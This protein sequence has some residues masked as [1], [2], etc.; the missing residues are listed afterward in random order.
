MDSRLATPVPGEGHPQSMYVTFGFAMGLL[1]DSHWDAITVARPL[2]RYFMIA[3]QPAN[4]LTSA[5]L[6]IDERI[7]HYLAG[8]NLLDP[9]LQ[10]LVR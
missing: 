4:N 6:R 5:P 7:L 9:R 2:R 8:D 3:V 10:R 1:P